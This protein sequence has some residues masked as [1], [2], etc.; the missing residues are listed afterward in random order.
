MLGRHRLAVDKWAEAY[1]VLES[2]ADEV[3]WCWSDI[4][5]RSDTVYV[6]GR[7]LLRDSKFAIT[8]SHTGFCVLCNI[9]EGSETIEWQLWRLGLADLIQKKQIGLMHG[10]NPHD[11]LDAVA[12]DLHFT[13]IVDYDVNIQAHCRMPEIYESAEKPYTFLML[14]GRLRS[15]RKY[16]IDLLRQRHLLDQAL[17][18]NLQSEVDTMSNSL[19]TRGHEDIRFLPPEYEIPLQNSQFDHSKQING[20][21]KPQLFEGLVWGDAIINP[22]AY[23]DTYFSLVTETI[24]QHSCTFATEKIWKPVIMCHPFVVAANRG[25]YRDLRNKGFRTFGHLIDESFDTID[26]PADR[27]QKIVDVVADIC[28][29]PSNFLQEAK[30][31]CEYNYQR[32]VEYN[33]QEKKRLVTALEAYLDE[34]LLR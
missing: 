25:F 31:T 3:F 13:N 10:G 7:E 27:A 14:N 22:K 24:Y 16:L 15:H 12:S 32:L 20:W 28:Q 34:R 5:P 33:Q 1:W 29:N 2:Y 18:S 6:L 30:S 23:I 11:K 9:A 4:T 19:M 17:W 21:I 8:N 26:D